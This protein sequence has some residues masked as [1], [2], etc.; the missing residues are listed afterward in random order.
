MKTI[1]I[2]TVGGAFFVG[3]ILTILIVYWLELP[4]DRENSV[5][6][7]A[8]VFVLSQGFVQTVVHILKY[9]INR[10]KKNTKRGK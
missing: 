7:V 4:S 3:L 9:V 10:A 6:Y 1:T 5:A 8:F 2:K